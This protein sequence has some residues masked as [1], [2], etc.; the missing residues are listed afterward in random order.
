MAGPEPAELR[1]GRARRSARS[2]ERLVEAVLATIRE[3]QAPTA[4]RVAA[5]AGVSLR[6]L[7]RLFEDLSG[8]WEAVRLRIAADVSSLLEPQAFEGDLR[9]RVHALVRQRIA[10]F[11]AIAPFRRWVDPREEQYPP[12][13][14]G[15][16]NLD[17]VLRA[18]A[19]AA[20]EP[21]LAAGADA[22]GPAFDALLSYES[23]NYL[24]TS[25][26]LGPRQVAT[27]LESAALR[28]VAPPGRG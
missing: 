10:I 15:R 7:F 9:Q 8:L 14:Q 22:L 16:E 21:E 17:R 28:L 11:E 18:Q 25:R 20:L 13:R 2:R 3:G 23:W 4:E 26:G 6:T 27:L 12:I 19:R 24:R 5:R 1:D